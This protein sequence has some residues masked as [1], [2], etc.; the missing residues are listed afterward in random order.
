MSRRQF[1]SAALC[2]TV[3]LAGWVTAAHLGSRS[4]SFETTGAIE[5]RRATSGSEVRVASADLM[6]PQPETPSV[7]PASAHLVPRPETPPVQI[8]A[9]SPLPQPEAPSV[10]V[11]AFP[12]MQ[13]L[14]LPPVQVAA[15]S[16]VSPEGT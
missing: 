2:G 9:A 16:P 8:A 14:D 7:S 4:H 5:G 15:A 11:A 3:V 10:Q 12:P 13:A 6:Q 1:A